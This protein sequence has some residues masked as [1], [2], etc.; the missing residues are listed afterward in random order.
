M[1]H[2]VYSNITCLLI[3]AGMLYFKLCYWPTFDTDQCFY[4]TQAWYN[5]F[6]AHK[7]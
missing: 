2:S 1:F 7:G 5:R 6:H 4:I 3:Y